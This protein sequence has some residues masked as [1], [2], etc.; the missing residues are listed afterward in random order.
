MNLNWVESRNET[1]ELVLVSADTDTTSEAELQLAVDAAVEY[2]V[3]L[4]PQNVRDESRYF[5]C[6]WNTQVLRLNIVVTDE[7]KMV[8]SPLVLE[9]SL[10]GMANMDTGAVSELVKFWIT[11]YL[12][13]CSAFLRFSVIAL[14][15]TGD[16][17]RGTLL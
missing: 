16:R 1:G 2:A 6:E 10:P 14:F 12:S 11:D 4:M 3:Q 15:H 13:T 17:T 9:L 7:S 5:I 8:E